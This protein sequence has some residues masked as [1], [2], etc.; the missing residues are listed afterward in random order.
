MVYHNSFIKINVVAGLKC[1]AMPELWFPQFLCT[2]SLFSAMFVK[3][4]RIFTN[5]LLGK[6]TLTFPLHM[7]NSLL[8]AR[9]FAGLY[10]GLLYFLAFLC[11]NHDPAAFYM[12]DSDLLNNPRSRAFIS[13]YLN[14]KEY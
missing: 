12:H 11:R 10:N 7:M 5:L 3:S 14:C 2:C 1:F 4:F 9:V 13:N 6:C 8:H